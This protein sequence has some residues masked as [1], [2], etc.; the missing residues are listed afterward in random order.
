MGFLLRLADP[1]AYV[2]LFVLAAAEASAFVGLFVPGET[3]MLVAGVLCYQGRASLWVM[4][5][6][7]CLGAIVGDSIG[8]EI[9]R[10]L[11]PRMMHSRLGRWI[12]DER[13]DKGQEALKQRGGRAIFFGRF[14][15][16]LRAIVPALAGMAGIPY[17]TFVVYNVAGGVIWATGFVLLGFAAGRSYQVVEKWA[18]RASLLLLIMFAVIVGIVFL[19]RWIA[20]HRE[21]FRERWHRFLERPR[22]ARLRDR[23]R[24]E[25]D[26]L[27]ARF[28][29][30]ER[31][32]LFVTAG[33]LLIVLI[34]WG[35]GSIMQ[36]V[37]AHDELALFDRPVLTYLVDHRTPGLT[38]AMKVVTFFG[39]NGF[40]V[41]ATVLVAGAVYVFTRKPRWSAFITG[42][43][44]GGYALFNLLK[45]LIERPRP[46]I[47]PAIHIGGS[48]FPSGHATVSAAFFLAAA[49][50]ATRK[51]GWVASV[52]VWAAALVV[53]ALVAFSRV[54]LGVHWPTDV[55]AGLMLGAAWTAITATATGALER[56]R[57]SRSPSE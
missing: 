36:D 1:W 35:F 39:G 10:H 44:A 16:L 24:R 50:L 4:I 5:V 26:W 54:Y 18:G 22:I 21:V 45:V 30:R 48:S 7:G 42:T 19:V 47:H 25:I 20:G 14:V 33:L 9:G 38:T 51:L 3:A 8:Y 27:V 55:V 41:P 52:W 28:D 23:R 32:G 12:G 29:P 56:P 37:L 40:I 53:P 46:S 34:A 13:W 11:G 49:Y 2:L 57:A 17:G 43:V 31:F 6:A 15:G